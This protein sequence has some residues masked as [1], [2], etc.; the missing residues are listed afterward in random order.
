MNI[1]YIGQYTPGTTSKMRADQL[2]EILNKYLINNQ[3]DNKK[4]NPLTFNIIDTN[5]P[6]YQTNRIWRSLGFRYKKGSLIKKINK[7]VINE[8]NSLV[9]QKVNKN[10]SNNLSTKNYELNPNPYDLIW[11]DKAIFLTPRTTQYLKPLT[12]KLVHF[13]PDM[14]FF[15][16]PSALFNKSLNYY[17]YLITTKIMEIGEYKKYGIENN[18]VITTQGFD[19]EIH[20][21]LTPFSDKDNCVTFIGLCEAAREKMIQSLINNQ[22]KVK[23]AG[24]GWMSFIENNKKNPYLTYL[25][26]GLFS[27]DYTKLL[28][29]SYFSLGLLY[30]QFPELHTTRTFEIP[31]CGTALITEKNEETSSFFTNEEAIFYNDINDMIDKIKYYQENLDELEILTQ[32]GTLRVHNDGRDYKS[33]MTNVLKGIGFSF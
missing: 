30:K 16:N 9:G 3:T 23:L 29:S 15:G 13:T 14:A 31:A 11:I 18:L 5:I 19:N 21:P 27:M 7:Y 32:K 4:I 10:S 33:I 1:L 22:I 17:D 24:K 20:K 26:E 12:N 2:K 25:G 8:V 6:F 28:S